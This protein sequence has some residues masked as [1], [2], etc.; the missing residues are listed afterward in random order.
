MVTQN[1]TALAHLT[2]QNTAITGRI[3]MKGGVN[4][5]K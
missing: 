3:L 4:Q 5:T 2:A 1:V